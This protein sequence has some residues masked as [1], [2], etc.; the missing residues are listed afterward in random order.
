VRQAEV[1][2][3]LGDLVVH[4]V[5]EGHPLGV[6]REPLAAAVQGVGVAVDADDPRLGEPLQHRLA[7]A[8][9]AE[10][11]VDEHGTR[12]RERRRDEGDDPVEEHRDVG[13]G[14]HGLGALPREGDQQEHR[15]GQRRGRGSGEDDDGHPVAHL[16]PHPAY[17]PGLRTRRRQPLCQ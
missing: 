10:G 4:R 2:E 3:H 7:V 13:G 12:L 9:E 5:H 11:G 8:A 15:A 1:G 16:V 14:G 6:R 17:R